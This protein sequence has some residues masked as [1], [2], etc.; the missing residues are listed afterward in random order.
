MLRHLYQ[1]T[2][3]MLQVAL[4]AELA[5]S[6]AQALRRGLAIG[7]F[8]D[9]P[10]GA[11][12]G[13][14][15]ITAIGGA[16]LAL[17]FPLLA[18]LRH[19]QRG[20]LRFRGL[21]RGAVALAAVGGIVFAL[22]ALLHVATQLLP[23]DARL[24]AVLLGKPLRYAGLASMAAG[25]LWAEMLRRSVAVPNAALAP[26]DSAGARIEVTHPRELATLAA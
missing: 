25:V 26:R 4:G 20:P 22:G 2:L 8:P 21:P 1:W 19:R 11:V 16:A 12:Q 18:L 6:L 23:A 14:A 24:A 5:P 10:L 13:A 3:V 9:G 17:S 7:A 15:A